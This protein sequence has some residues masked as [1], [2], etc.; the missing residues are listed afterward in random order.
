ML[1]KILI[2]IIILFLLNTHT[3]ISCEPLSDTEVLIN[4]LIKCNIELLDFYP[5]RPPVDYTIFLTF[6]KYYIFIVYIIKFISL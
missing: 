3:V 2:I 6:I 4:Q 5:R 1:Q